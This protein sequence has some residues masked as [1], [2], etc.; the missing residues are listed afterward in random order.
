MLQKLQDGIA[1]PTFGAFEMVE[2]DSESDPCPEDSPDKIEQIHKLMAELPSWEVKGD[3]KTMDYFRV[4]SIDFPYVE[5]RLHDHN[6]RISLLFSG[7]E[8]RESVALTFSL[9]GLDSQR[10]ESLMKTKRPLEK[11]LSDQPPIN[12]Y[13]SLDVFQ[14]GGGSLVLP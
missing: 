2:S 13:K 8:T 12:N 4:Y 5:G 6:S 14:P 11:S 7:L 3:Q 1:L 9:V 10:E